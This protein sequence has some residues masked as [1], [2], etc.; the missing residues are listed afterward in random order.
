MAAEARTIRALVVLSA[1]GVL[2]LLRE[3][4]VTRG[5]GWPGVLVAATLVGTA[6]IS[7][8]LLAPSPVAVPEAGAEGA[9][10]PA[11]VHA[12]ESEGF[13]LAPEADPVEAVRRGQVSRALI[14]D[15]D[16]AQIHAVPWAPTRGLESVIRDTVGAS[17]RLRS[18]PSPRGGEMASPGALAA[19]LG[20]LF[21]L[22]GVV[23]GAALVSR[24]RD[25][26]LLECEL[27][28]GIPRYVPALARLLAVGVVLAVGFA[29]TV[30]LLVALVVLPAPWIWAFHGAIG[31]L[32]GAALGLGFTSRGAGFSAP[33]SRALTVALGLVGLGFGAPAVG[34]WLPI[35]SMAA[36]AGGRPVN[37]EATLL[38]VLLVGWACRGVSRGG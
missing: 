22:Y 11:L 30:V 6:A 29:A 14:Q 17:W 24:D 21:S 5:L 33:L 37:G 4:M 19:L 31:G 2:R 26:G 9:L 38:L 28:L 7:G 27:A 1:G 25:S 10:T 36:L 32:G 3:P 13:V 35:A 18:S 20:A 15:K 12:L 34:A 23:L 16:G 8:L